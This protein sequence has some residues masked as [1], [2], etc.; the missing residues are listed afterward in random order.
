MGGGQTIAMIPILFLQNRS[1]KGGAQTCLW[2][3]L[4]HAKE[5]GLWQPL[6]VTSSPG[7]LVD[8][9]QASGIPVIIQSFPRSRSLWGRS[10][11]NALFIHNILAKLGQSAFVP[12]LVQGNDHG[13]GI[14]TV[15]LAKKL[16]IPASVF[17]RDSRM[18]KQ[19]YFKYDCHACQL[20]VAIGTVLQK[21]VMAWDDKQTIY[22]MND[23]ILLNEINSPLPI[24][25]SPPQEILVI[26]SHLASKGWADLVAALRLLEQEGN[27]LAG[28]RFDFTGIRDDLEN[29]LGDESLTTCS[30]RFLGRVN[31]FQEWVR[32]YPLVINPSR[33]ETF[34]MA[35]VEVIASGVPLL[36][37]RCG[38]IE[39]I[40]E[41]SNYLYQAGNAIELAKKLAFLLENWPNC[42]LDLSRCQTLLANQF[43]V[44]ITVDL[45]NRHY[46]HLT[47][48]SPE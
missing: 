25:P 45:L 41:D 44:G 5:Q 22:T 10:V 40:I 34:G 29:P 14:L 37:S 21:Q 33:M 27:M 6:L 31:P 12:A 46:R 39:H 42:A 1:Q 9:C 15:D 23:G 35:A 7:W 28:K 43:N 32:R 20:V 38:V 18:R 47:G 3:M 19:D 16:R 4:V 24:N 2:R 11:G 26:G 8:A 17:L 48:I 13:E 30:L 36:S